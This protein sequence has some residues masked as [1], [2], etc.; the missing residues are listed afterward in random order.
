MHGEPSLSFFLKTHPFYQKKTGENTEKEN[1]CCHN[2]S[3]LDSAAAA[4][5]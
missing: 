2:Y 4:A 5:L 3:Y 1:N